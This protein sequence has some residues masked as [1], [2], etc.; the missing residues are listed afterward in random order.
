MGK[1]DDAIS[2][3]GGSDEK[4]K[5]LL[6]QHIRDGMGYSNY[7][8]R[9][10]AEASGPA[11][12]GDVKGLSPAGIKSRIASR[13]G[14][15]DQNINSLRGMAGAIDTA[16][17]GIAANQIAEGK[18]AAAAKKNAMGLEN[19]VAFEPKSQLD[20]Q[21]LSY[22][23]NPKNADGSVKSLQQFES[24]LNDY[25]SDPKYMQS[26]PKS[27]QP[28]QV[29]SAE[30][31]KK[32]IQERLPQDFIGNED[33]YHF[34]AQGYS[35]K[36]AEELQGGLRYDTMS[37]PEKLIYQVQ[38]P[39][40]AKML[41]EGGVNKELLSDIGTTTNPDTGETIPKYTFD[42]LKEKYPNVEVTTLK[43]MVKPVEKK[44]IQKNIDEF[45]LDN[46]D[47]MEELKKEKVE[48]GGGISGIMKSDTYKEF[49]TQMEMQ[50]GSVFTSSEIDQMIYNTIS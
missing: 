11:S 38:N 44:S 18:A 24:E 5:N 33:K 7:M 26:G 32:T 3:Y 49:K 39:Q 29:H 27:D 12:I 50:Y 20:Q 28:Y 14:D 23:Q 8:S 40:M 10:G 25:Y 31:I 13:F 2:K 36:Q 41:D 22:M 9:I 34:M 17:G 30:E 47:A 48:K 4:Y 19:N 16:A 6:K 46:R 21:I 35:Q 42:E 1:L 37:E 43:E 15:Q 45:Y